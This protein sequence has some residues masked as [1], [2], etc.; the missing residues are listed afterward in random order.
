MDWW[1][2]NIAGAEHRRKSMWFLLATLPAA[3]CPHGIFKLPQNTLQGSAG[4]L[5]LLPGSPVSC[6]STPPSGLLRQAQL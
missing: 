5:C 6:Q 2:G 4:P 3:D 1:V